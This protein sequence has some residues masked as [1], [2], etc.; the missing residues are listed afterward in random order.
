MSWSQTLQTAL[1]AN[2]QTD[3][4]F[5]PPDDCEKQLESQECPHSRIQGETSHS[6]DS[7]SN[8]ADTN[9]NSQDSLRALANALTL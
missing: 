6:A 3:R 4:L 5:P 8:T 2:S 1:P 7:S 9:Y